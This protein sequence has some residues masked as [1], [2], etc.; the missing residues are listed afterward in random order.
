[1]YWTRPCVVCLTLNNLL[2][3]KEFIR[4]APVR[5]LAIKTAYS[6]AYTWSPILVISIM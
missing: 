5:T 6:W 1:M 4:R 2:V 3:V